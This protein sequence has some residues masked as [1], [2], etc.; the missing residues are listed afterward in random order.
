MLDHRAVRHKVSKDMSGSEHCGISIK[1]RK[2]I[3]VP[4]PEKLGLITQSKEAHLKPMV[5]FQRQIHE[6][7]TPDW[8]VVMV[9]MTG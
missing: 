9:S 3:S 2:S 6:W 7:D 4:L 8:Q 1:T 5:F